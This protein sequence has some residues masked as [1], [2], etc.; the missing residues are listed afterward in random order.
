MF[1]LIFYFKFTNSV[2]SNPISPFSLKISIS[3]LCC[4]R[5]LRNTS[6][7][8]QNGITTLASIFS[9]IFGAFF[10]NCAHAV[11]AAEIGFGSVFHCVCNAN[12]L[13]FCRQVPILAILNFST[14]R[15]LIQRI[16]LVFLNLKFNY[17]EVICQKQ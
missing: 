10:D 13:V 6:F 3:S 4:P 5:V 16:N 15:I 14:L 7:P 2:C 1:W 17:S 9:T 11:A 12:S 8:S